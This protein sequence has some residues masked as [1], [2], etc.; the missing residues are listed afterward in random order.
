MWAWLTGYDGG[1]SGR[2]SDG[3][4]DDDGVAVEARL[5]G[6]GGVLL[7]VGILLLFSRTQ[8]TPHRLRRAGGEA[9]LLRVRLP[10]PGERDVRLITRIIVLERLKH[11][12]CFEP[13]LTNEIHTSPLS[14]WETDHNISGSRLRW[15]YTVIQ[16]QFYCVYT[17]RKMAARIKV[18][19]TIS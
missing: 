11:T 4:R 14:S 5:A 10:V 6:P 3:D 7:V 12:G 17:Q 2:A 1:L 19:C 18:F 9:V 15:C 13:F 16:T 8:A